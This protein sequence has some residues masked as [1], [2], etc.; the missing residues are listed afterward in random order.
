MYNVGKTVCLVWCRKCPR[1]MVPKQNKYIKQK[2]I[3][4]NKI[5]LQ[6]SRSLIVQTNERIGKMVSNKRYI[7]TCQG[8]NTI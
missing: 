8:L 7:V 1:I 4:L 3:N 5:R 2:K 6:N